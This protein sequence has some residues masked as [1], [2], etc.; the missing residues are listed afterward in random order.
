MSTR[1]RHD[2][3]GAISQ[4]QSTLNRWREAQAKVAE[5]WADATAQQFQEENLQGIEPLLNRTLA[6]LQEANDLVRSLEKRV[7]DMRSD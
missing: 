5:Q 2:I 4:M 1:C 3:N 7:Q 6:A